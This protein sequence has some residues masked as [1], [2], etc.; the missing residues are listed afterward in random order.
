MF[1]TTPPA[2]FGWS[3]LQT[4]V[5]PWNIAMAAR[6][7]ISPRCPLCRQRCNPW[8]RQETRDAVLASLST[9]FGRDLSATKHACTLNQCFGGHFCW[10]QTVSCHC[11]VFGMST[12]EWPFQNNNQTCT[13]IC[14]GPNNGIAPPSLRLT[15]QMI[16]A[17]INP[18]VTI[19][20]K[21]LGKAHQLWLRPLK[22]TA[23]GVP[24]QT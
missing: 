1:E 11:A 19:Y 9:R 18:P 14:D 16:S 21:A 8:R 22:W 10:F 2:G 15:R 5:F 17:Y 24:H 20:H 6:E 4:N 7:K 3:W 23:V 13:K 12:S